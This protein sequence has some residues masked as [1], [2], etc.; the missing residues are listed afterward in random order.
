MVFLSQ[1]CNISMNKLSYVCSM[2]LLIDCRPW[3][4]S[5]GW[6][7]IAPAKIFSFP[8]TL[9]L[10]K[11][12]HLV[13]WLRIVIIIRILFQQFLA[14]LRQFHNGSPWK[15]SNFFKKTSNEFENLSLRSQAPW[16]GIQYSRLESKGSFIEKWEES[17]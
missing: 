5:G 17:Q 4:K 9:F 11:Q 2:S 8:G 13:S 7:K 12:R 10:L 15:W 3:R 14:D 16:L 1:L 6:L